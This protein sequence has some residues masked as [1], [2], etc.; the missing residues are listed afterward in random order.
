[1]KRH[2]P[3]PST[4]CH[5]ASHD[6]SANHNRA[7]VRMDGAG[8]RKK[9][10]KDYE[11]ALRDLEK[12]RRQLD[13]FH[14]T[15][16]PQFT[17]WLNTQFGALLTELRE[18][19]QKMA[20]DEQ[21]IIQVENEAMFSR[22][23][24]A[25][26]YR[27]VKELRENPEPHKARSAGGGEPAGGRDPF[28]AQPES[29][30][31]GEE[32][33]IEE[34]INE[35]IREFGPK[36]QPQDNHGSRSGQRTESVAPVHASAGLKELYRAVV[37]RLHPDSQL[38]G[39]RHDPA[40]NFSLRADLDALAVQ[41]RRALMDD[42]ERMRCQCRTIQEMIARWKVAAERLKQPSRRRNHPQNREFSF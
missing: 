25:L 16:L 6:H 20:A 4:S 41:T 27:R 32:N 23:S 2:A 13:Q 31:D 18:L 1:M 14:Q 7:L 37:R 35:F 8:V 29:G 11:K 28:G 36:V 30:T 34:F 38:A 5:A 24:D 21:L 33:P 26:A 42:L 10:K 39:L 17:R 15:D 3:R 12:T 19:C 40:W 22:C 9:I